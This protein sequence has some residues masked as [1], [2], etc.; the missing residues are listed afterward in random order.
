[1]EH[2]EYIQRKIFFSTKS[3]KKRGKEKRIILQILRWTALIQ[4]NFFFI[5]K[6]KSFLEIKQ[7]FRNIFYE[8]WKDQIRH[9]LLWRSTFVGKW[10]EKQGWILQSRQSIFFLVEQ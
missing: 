2:E 3:K 8:Q 9:I 4:T 1:M 7:I 5:F 6:N 10:R